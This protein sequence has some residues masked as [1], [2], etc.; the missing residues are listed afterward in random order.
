[1]QWQ[2]CCENPQWKSEVELSEKGRER[3]SK[4]HYTKC[5]IANQIMILFSIW[6]FIIK[7]VK[8]WR[9][10]ECNIFGCTRI[11]NVIRRTEMTLDS[12]CQH[13]EPLYFNLV[14]L[15][16]GHLKHIFM[17]CIK[18]EFGQHKSVSTGFLQSG[19][20]IVFRLACGIL[21]SIWKQRA[22]KCLIYYS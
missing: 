10:D 20:H 22:N 4:M 6:V 7:Q 1:M 11:W 17:C 8:I 19:V 2:L 12:L 9:H 5:N 3:W 13:N 21:I 18:Q 16:T 15:S 14:V